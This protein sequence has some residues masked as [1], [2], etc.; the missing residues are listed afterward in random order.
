MPCQVLSRAALALSSVQ[1]ISREEERT[2]ARKSGVPVE[3][4]RIRTHSHS[5]ETKPPDYG[6]SIGYEHGRLLH[7]HSPPALAV[8]LVAL[9]T[10]IWTRGPEGSL[11]RWGRQCFLLRGFV[12]PHEHPLWAS[13]QVHY[14]RGS[15][16]MIMF[17][18]LGM[19][20]DE[21]QVGSSDLLLTNPSCPSLQRPLL[22]HSMRFFL[23]PNLPRSS[24]TCIQFSPGR[25]GLFTQY[26]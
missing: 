19:G 26:N 23:R 1:A 3:T 17:S 5:A 12:R 11:A 4:Q 22:S 9:T 14:C 24:S 8:A 15:S 20:C 16:L 13:A 2:G 18:S 21:Q 10:P 25:P 7:V 6:W